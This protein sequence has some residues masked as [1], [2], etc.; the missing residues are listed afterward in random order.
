MYWGDFLEQVNTA[1]GRRCLALLSDKNA[2]KKVITVEGKLK[3]ECRKLPGNCTSPMAPG[4]HH[5]LNTGP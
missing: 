3:K 4:Y 5:S 2:K 1:D